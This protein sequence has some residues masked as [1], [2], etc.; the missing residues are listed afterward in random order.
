AG[1][2]AGRARGCYGQRPQ[3]DQRNLASAQGGGAARSGIEV[4]DGRPG[5]RWLGEDQRAPGDDAQL[6]AGENRESAPRMGTTQG[7]VADDSAE[8][9]ARART[10]RTGLE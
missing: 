6:T 10:H 9:S 5:A 4:R 1:V 2:G 7:R 3:A 8:E